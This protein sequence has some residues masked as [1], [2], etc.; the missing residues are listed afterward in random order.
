MLILLTQLLSYRRINQFEGCRLVDAAA[1]RMCQ[2]TLGDCQVIMIPNFVG[3]Q[4]AI[5]FRN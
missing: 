5:F 4:T 1:R 3:L 2:R